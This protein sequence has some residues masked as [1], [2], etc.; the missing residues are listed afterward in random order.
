[1]SP[2]QVTVTWIWDITVITG[3]AGMDPLGYG[4]MI[5]CAVQLTL[6]SLFIILF[7]AASPNVIPQLIIAA[8]SGSSSIIDQSIIDGS[9]LGL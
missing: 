7:P 2:S 8:P 9:C 6:S 4:V 5:I 3:S 1:M